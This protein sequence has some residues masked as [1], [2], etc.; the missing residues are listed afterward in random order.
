MQ[1]FLFILGEGGGGNGE[2][3]VTFKWRSR[4]SEN[5]YDIEPLKGTQKLKYSNQ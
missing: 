2:G 4:T 1:S 5:L 3:N